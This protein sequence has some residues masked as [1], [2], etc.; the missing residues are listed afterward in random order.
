MSNSKNVLLMAALMV[1]AVIYM[2]KAKASSGPSGTVK[3]LNKQE[4]ARNI[5]DP[6]WTGLL[7]GAWKA[8]KT[9]QT[10]DGSA[11]FLKRDFLGRITT[12][13]GKPV[14]QQLADAFPYA[15]G[16]GVTEEIDY[17]STP[18]YIDDVFPATAGIW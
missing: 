4:E 13:D 11:A 18:N 3:A 17:G 14:G 12:S 8:L 6:M 15:Y 9:A 1:G 10:K 16:D 7:G 5:N 2:K